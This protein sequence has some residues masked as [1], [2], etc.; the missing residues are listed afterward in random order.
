MACD[1]VLAG[2][3]VATVGETGEGSASSEAIAQNPQPWR[4]ARWLH[5]GVTRAPRIARSKTRCARAGRRR[6]AALATRPTI[7]NSPDCQ[8]TPPTSDPLGGNIKKSL[9]V[10]LLLL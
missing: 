9:I 6:I 4:W 7:R 3:G 1:D 5:G 8:R 10:P 2:E